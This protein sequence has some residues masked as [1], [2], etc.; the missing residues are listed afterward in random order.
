MA[1]CTEKTTNN[2]WNKSMKKNAVICCSIFRLRHDINIWKLI[3][4]SKN[5]WNQTRASVTCEFL[6]PSDHWYNLRWE[7]LNQRNVYSQYLIHNHQLT[8]FK[9]HFHLCNCLKLSKVLHHPS[10]TAWWII[11]E[12]FPINLLPDV[13][14]IRKHIWSNQIDF[15]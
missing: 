12:T 15:S 3:F 7:N 6:F 14:E 8:C 1:T 10:C 2:P 13:N 5:Q 9:W 11:W 4:I